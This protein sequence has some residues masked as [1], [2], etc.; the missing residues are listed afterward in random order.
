MERSV[1]SDLVV[2]NQVIKGWG[3]ARIRMS[4]IP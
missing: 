1:H 3:W 2:Y 4:V